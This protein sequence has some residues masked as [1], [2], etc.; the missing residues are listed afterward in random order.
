MT[1]K[2]TYYIPNMLSMIFWVFMV[3]QPTVIYL[4]FQNNPVYGTAVILSCTIAFCFV[5]LIWM[6]AVF[7]KNGALF[8]KKVRGHFLILFFCIWANLSIFW[9]PGELSV[10]FVYGSILL[11]QVIIAVVICSHMRESDCLNTIKSIVFAS[12]IFSLIAF[13]AGTTDDGRLGDGEFLH[14]NSI[15][16]ASSLAL[17][18][19]LYLYKV[20]KKFYVVVCMIIFTIL[21]LL[22]FSK[23]SIIATYLAISISV[24]FFTGGA[25]KKSISILIAAFMFMVFSVLL[26]DK[27]ISYMYLYDGKL[28][29][30]VSGR[31]FIWEYTL[32]QILDNPFLGYG[33]MSFRD[34]GAPVFSFRTI[35]A[36]NE[37]LQIWFS[38]GV[39][40]LFLLFSIYRNLIISLRLSLS[41]DRNVAML[42][43][44]II[45]YALVKGVTEANV[46]GSVVPFPILILIF[47]LLKTNKCR[48]DIRA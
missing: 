30:T 4:F 10:L 26:M 23:T 32:I 24:F 29:Y 22:S 19:S 48:L 9:A 35:Q 7:K 41:N 2:N 34:V 45:I 5:L 47:S 21:L 27:I 13:F 33:L 42:A 6:L 3:L 44:S 1:L 11:G 16:S 18:F 37:L 28:V 25:G 15:G 38:Y 12:L 39:V 14:P 17:I 36:H 8:E 43:M 40:G 46:M 31:S 20:E